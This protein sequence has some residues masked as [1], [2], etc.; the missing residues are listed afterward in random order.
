MSEHGDDTPRNSESDDNARE[1]ISSAVIKTLYDVFGG[2]A[3]G[4]VFIVSLLVFSTFLVFLSYIGPVELVN[5]DL[6]TGVFLRYPIGIVLLFLLWVTATEYLEIFRHFIEKFGTVFWN[7]ATDENKFSEPYD[8]KGAYREYRNEYV[9][10]FSQFAPIGVV[11]LLTPLPFTLGYYGRVNLQL[12]AGSYL[13]IAI[14]LQGRANKFNNAV[15]SVNNTIRSDVKHQVTVHYEFVFLLLA[16]IVQTAA[17]LGV[18][19]EELAGFILMIISAVA[20]LV[21]T[22]IFLLYLPHLEIQR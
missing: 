5:V 17:S 8:E 22:F 14:L 2:V 9:D 3:V 6:S 21:I 1:V 19:T 11:L 20:S 7:V 4:F 13:I 16:G 10:Y 15:D 12:V 18:N